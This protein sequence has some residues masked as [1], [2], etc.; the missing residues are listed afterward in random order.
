MPLRPALRR[1]IPP[2]LLRS[3]L[4]H[5]PIQIRT[6][7]PA[8]TENS[9]PLLTRRSDRALPKLRDINNP[10]RTWRHIPLF[11]GACAAAGFGIF[12]YQKASSSVVTS[13]LYALRVNPLAREM[14]GDEI[15]FAHRVPWIWGRVDTLHGVVDVSF[16]VKGRRGAGMM[17]F[18]CARGRGMEFVSF[19]LFFGLV[20]RLIADFWMFSLRRRS[21]A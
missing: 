9:G 6:L 4:H 10:L 1:P 3:R 11:L 14:L 15:Y 5:H 8:P 17:R 19:S 21:G 18:R 13:S 12:N 7:I 16:R 20:D 2:H